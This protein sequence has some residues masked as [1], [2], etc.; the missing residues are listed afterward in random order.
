MIIRDKQTDIRDKKEYIG[1]KESEK[2]S[3]PHAR[4]ALLNIWENRERGLI[5]CLQ[6]S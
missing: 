3:C 1:E 4:R 6:I 5:I 2:I